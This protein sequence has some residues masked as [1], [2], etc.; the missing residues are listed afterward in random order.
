MLRVLLRNTGDGILQGRVASLPQWIQITPMTFATRHRQ[1][2]TV[3]ADATH[4]VD[5]PGDYSDV[6]VFETTGGKPQLTVACR[7]LPQRPKFSDIFAWYLPLMALVLLPLLVSLV[8]TSLTRS[9]DGFHPVFVAGLMVSG[10]LSASLL[11]ITAA[12]DAGW[13]ERMLPALGILLAPVGVVMFHHS[14]T[15][16]GL[17]K[18][19]WPVVVQSL[20]PTIVLLGLQGTAMVRS[21][22]S[23]GRWQ[24]WAWILGI[25]CLGLSFVMWQSPIWNGLTSLGH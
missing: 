1:P 9:H 18:E 25:T 14:L 20:L 19:V 11:A 24:L 10:L 22:D 13:F 7:V 12:S 5:G 2:F 3:V 16:D 6:V 23:V 15:G 17:G 4:L 21:P 8:A